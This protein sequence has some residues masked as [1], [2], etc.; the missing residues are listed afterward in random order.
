M[1]ATIEPFSRDHLKVAVS[2]VPPVW[3]ST[4]LELILEA[5]VSGGGNGLAAAL[6]VALASVGSHGAGA[7]GGCWL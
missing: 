6:V 2:S 1:A 4:R 3:I 7:R 5:L